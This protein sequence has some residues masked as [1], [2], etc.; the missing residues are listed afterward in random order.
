MIF[1]LKKQKGQSL[2]EVII[3]MAIFAVISGAIMSVTLG[4]LN[5]LTQG[6][7]E[8]E[9]RALAEQAIEAIRSVRDGAWNELIY[10]INI[11]STS[12]GSW[13][14]AS[15]SSELINNKYLRKIS[16][17]DVC[18]DGS[19]NITNCP[20]TYTDPHIKFA[21]TTI[22]WS[23]RYNAT[24][25]VEQSGFITNWESRDW[26]QTD[27]S[28]S[29]GQAI[30][31]DSTKYDSDNGNLDTTNPGEISLIKPTNSGTTTWPFSTSSDYTFNASKIVVA[32]DKAELV[33]SGS[34][35][36]CSGTPN[37]CSTF[38]S[39]STCT[40]QV[41]CSWGGSGSGSSLAWSTVWGTY[42]DWQTAGNVDGTSPT[43]GG[44]PTN[45][46]DIIIIRN[47]GA[48]T[49]SGYWQNSFVTSVANPST[50]TINF[51]WS[52]KS[53]NSG[54]LTS[55]TIYVFVDNFAGDPTI[56]TQ[57]WSQNVTGTTPWASVT[58]LNIASKLTTAGTY[59]I[60]L[61]ARVIKTGGSPPNIDNTVGWDNVSLNWSGVNT[62]TGTPNACNTFATS[63]SCSTQLSCSWTGSLTYPIDNPPINPN[64]TYVGT[65]IK[66]WTGFSE[67]ATKGTGE[68]YYQL[69]VDGSN[70][71]YWNGSIWATSTLA[72][73]FNT[74]SVINT[75]IGS[76]STSTGQITFKAF[77]SSDGT[78]QV[79]LDDVRLGYF[80]V[81]NTYLSPA[82][83]TSSAFNMSNASPVQIIEWD[84]TKPTNTDIKFQIRTAP[85]SGGSPGTWTPW[86]GATG[87]STFFTNKFGAVVSNLLNGNRWVQYRAEL[88]SSDGVDTPV[89]TEVRVNYK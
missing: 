28:G 57:V 26:I 51:D 47:N 74:A 31:S 52:I 22:S 23:P 70:W 58:N 39:T 89:L 21:S 79:S 63:S 49:V 9:A 65:D 88:S 17:S 46:K 2:V 42:F 33:S 87:T 75:N 67:T 41:G 73:D 44:N 25:T 32:A 36:S 1:F 61:V 54:F 38:V 48:A 50:A 24:N 30:W 81:S 69:S 62:C 14:L 11:I 56:G 80:G 72:T 13:T 5:G 19:N 60:K 64:S 82:Y 29:S 4:S 20:G 18:R 78:Q 84:E 83:A 7:D 27:W 59:Y 37:A 15:S 85:D 53:Y 71:K 16:L 86:Y 34:G 55:Y 35:G 12:T 76:F 68:I 45:Y 43:T 6:G 8:T 77:L 3:A 66:Q 10:P 40:N